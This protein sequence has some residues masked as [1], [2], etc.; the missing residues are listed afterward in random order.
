MQSIEEKGGFYKQVQEGV[1]QSE[2]GRIAL[3]RMQNVDKR[4]DVFVGV[5]MFANTLEQP[6]EQP[7]GH[8]KCDLQAYYEKVMEFQDS[9]RPGLETALNELSI[10]KDTDNMINNLVEAFVNDAT[11]EEAFDQILPEEGNLK[12]ESLHHCYAAM[13]L[14]NLRCKVTD[15]QQ[16]KKT[17]L[18]VF[19]ANMGPIQQHKPRADF[20]TGFL[21][22]GGFYVAG[23][24][25][26]ATVKEAADAAVFSK[27]QT[28]C[29][30]STDDTY[31]ELVPQLVSSIKA[32]KP[33]MIFILAG[34]PQDMV[35][36]YKQQGI[37]IFVHL[38]ANVLDTLS[39]LAK[40]MGVEL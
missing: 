32:M 11:L 2:A 35:A 23:N 20:A 27:S 37:D 19:L 31:Q 9:P 10:H 25:G 34:Y 18:S 3:D 26:F 38:R 33:D 15:F 17:V 29:I 28:V 5:N 4:K 39:D 30:C 21:Q 12:T 6:L 40:R 14:E 1:I 36:T 8:C 22:V 24:D 7:E 16:S 13:G